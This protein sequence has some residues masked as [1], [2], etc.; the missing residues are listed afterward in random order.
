MNQLELEK[1]LGTPVA[2]SSEAD[3]S[4]DAAQGLAFGQLVDVPFR[5]NFR[6]IDV[7]LPKADKLGFSVQ[8]FDT[9]PWFFVKPPE[10]GFVS[11]AHGGE[12][13]EED[14]GFALNLSSPDTTIAIVT[15]QNEGLAFSFDGNILRTSLLLKL[16]KYSEPEIDSPLEELSLQLVE[17]DPWLSERS[18][19]LLNASN[20][21][22]VVGMGLVGRHRP[23]DAETQASLKAAADAGGPIRL[24]EPAE[25]LWF[26]GLPDETKKWVYEEI[27]QRSEDLVGAL[28]DA[29]EGEVDEV[30]MLDRDDIESAS[31]VALHDDPL[32]ALADEL[33]AQLIPRLPVATERQ[34]FKA[35]IDYGDKWW[36]QSVPYDFDEL[37]DLDLLDD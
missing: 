4:S 16:I 30:L 5:Q 2:D 23:L 19:E 12:V 33:G 1:W 3:L 22:V 29:L 34:L 14:G 31:W 27:R 11:K 15:Q 6:K 21:G 7:W 18:F 8:R 24:P 28:E 13:V 10:P 25:R 37:D 36:T 9:L 35:A 26:K 32:M 17:V 20:W